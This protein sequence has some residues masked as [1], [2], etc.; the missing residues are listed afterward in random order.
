MK[1]KTIFRDFREEYVSIKSMDFILNS[2]RLR[3]D[4]PLNP[5][6]VLLH[7]QCICVFH[8]VLTIN[9]GCFPKQY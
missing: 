9:S 2:R 8:M 1:L 6:L 5:T 4:S 7:T 3:G